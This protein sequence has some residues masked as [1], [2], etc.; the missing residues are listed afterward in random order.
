M[1]CGGYWHEEHKLAC[2]HLCRYLYGAFC[3]FC[4]DTPYVCA[5][6]VVMRKV[7]AI[8]LALLLVGCGGSYDDEQR[9]EYIDKCIIEVGPQTEKNNVTDYC[10]AKWRQLQ[11]EK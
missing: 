8:I 4:D 11:R 1:T 9:Q 5:G 7:A 2:F 10:F 6:G 3:V